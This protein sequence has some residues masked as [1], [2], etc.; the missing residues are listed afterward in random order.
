[1]IPSRMFY[2]SSPSPTPT[3]MHVYRASSEFPSCRMLATSSIEMRL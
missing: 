1:M 2:H 3:R